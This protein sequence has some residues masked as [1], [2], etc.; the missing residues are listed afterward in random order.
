MK[1]LRIL[2]QYC[3]RGLRFRRSMI[4]SGLLFFFGGIGLTIAAQNSTAD[5]SSIPASRFRI[6]EKLTYSVSFGK[7]DNAAY[8]QTCVVSRGKI[9]GKDAVELHSK[10]KTL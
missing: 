2:F 3:G 5:I 10:I 7:F 6:G 9:A 8:A 1:K 4:L